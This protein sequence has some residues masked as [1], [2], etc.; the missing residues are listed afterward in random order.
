MEKSTWIF[1]ISHGLIEADNPGL[2]RNSGIPEFSKILSR[3][4]PGS[5]D[6]AV[7]CINLPAI[8]DLL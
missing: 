3:D 2:V 1:H 5:R 6:W 8:Q 7:F 4:I